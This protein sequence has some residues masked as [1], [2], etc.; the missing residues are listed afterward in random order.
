MKTVLARGF[1]GLTAEHLRPVWLAVQKAC[2]S[3]TMQTKKERRTVL[4]DEKYFIV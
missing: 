2:G 3:K 4:A 1:C